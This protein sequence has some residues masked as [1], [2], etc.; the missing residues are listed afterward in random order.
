MSAIDG[1][2]CLNP[3]CTGAMLAGQAGGGGALQRGPAPDPPDD[4]PGH[5]CLPGRIL[6]RGRGVLRQGNYCL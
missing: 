6:G 5:P 4:L 3:I 2:L 1:L